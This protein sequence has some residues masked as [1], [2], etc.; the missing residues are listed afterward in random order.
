MRETERVRE[1]ASKSTECSSILYVHLQYVCL[2]LS[3]IL[4]NDQLVIAQIKGVGA[5]LSQISLD[6]GPGSQLLLPKVNEHQ[7]QDLPKVSRSQ[8]LT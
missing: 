1:R 8:N 4:K 5:G 7:N 2:S 3:I 6:I